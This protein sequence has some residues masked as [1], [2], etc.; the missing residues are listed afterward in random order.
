MF[1]SSTGAAPSYTVAWSALTWSSSSPAPASTS[2][3]P[4]APLSLR[5]HQGEHFTP[6][7]LGGRGQQSHPPPAQPWPIQ[8]GGSLPQPQLHKLVAPSQQPRWPSLSARQIA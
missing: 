7:R 6:L 1:A 3:S 4:S 8:H 2:A 5:V